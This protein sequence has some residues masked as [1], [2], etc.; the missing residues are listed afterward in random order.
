MKKQDFVKAVAT[1]AWVSQDVAAKLINTFTEVI[2]E[3]LI[4]WEK[5]TL[6]GFGSWQVNQRKARNGINPKTGEKIK[7]PAMKSPAF[8]SGKTLKEAV[9]NT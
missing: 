9:R 5:I 3:E 4:N 8:K 1:K 6:T 2:T 7:I